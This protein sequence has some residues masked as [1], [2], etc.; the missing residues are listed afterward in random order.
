MKS[1]KSIKILTFLITSLSILSGTLN[2]IFPSLIAFPDLT[3]L[4]SLHANSL[5]S[6]KIWQF[7]THLLIYPA[8]NGIHIFY[9]INLFFGIMILQRFGMAIIQVKGEKNFLFYFFT[10]GIVSGIAAFL[11]MIHSGSA[12]YYAAPTS[13]IYSLLVATIFLFPKLDLMFLLT[14]SIKGKKLVPGLIGVILLINLSSG[15]YTH[16]FATLSGVVT[17]YLFILLFWKTESP[18]AFMQKFDQTI[19]RLSEGKITAAFKSTRL[20]K[21]T[22]NTRIYDINTGEAVLSEESF[23]NACLEK[24][25]KEGKGSLTLYERFRLHRY[26]KK[27]AKK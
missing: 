14:P 1:I 26:S 6:F 9:L 4:L 11:T 16:F 12:S 25:S 24:I 21:Y 13:A 23:I 2:K 10:C 7:V 8:P 5:S 15:D 22:D 27:T 19:T 17:A 3:N 20:D 18:Y